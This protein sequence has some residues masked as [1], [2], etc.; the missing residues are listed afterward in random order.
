MPIAST[1]WDTVVSLHNEEFPQCARTAELLCCKFQEV[2]QK[3]GPTGE[4]Q[5]P[6][7]IRRV[8]I[9][10]RQFIQMIDSLT[11]SSDG[12]KSDEDES[13]LDNE[14]ILLKE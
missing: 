10:N 11:G 12:S 13:E 1:E 3:T 6:A 7:H 14:D 2:V 5:C 8:K 4:P 9:I